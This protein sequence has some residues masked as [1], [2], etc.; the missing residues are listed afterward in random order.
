MVSLYPGNLFFTKNG[1]KI[2]DGEFSGVIE[3]DPNKLPAIAKKNFHSL[4]SKLSE[5]RFT[6][7]IK[8][9]FLDRGKNTPQMTP[10]TKEIMEQIREDI[11]PYHW[12]PYWWQRCSK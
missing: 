11:D 8:Q 7:W 9:T 5:Y 12:R 6:T 1:L 10:K 3:E 2:V 4:T